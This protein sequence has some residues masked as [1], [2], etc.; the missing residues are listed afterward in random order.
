MEGIPATAAMP[1]ELGGR[2]SGTSGPHFRV[3]RSA[4]RLLGKLGTT[5]SGAL[6]QQP[7]SILD[8]GL[9]IVACLP[10]KQ[11]FK[12]SPVPGRGS[13]NTGNLQLPWGSWNLD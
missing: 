1:R 6:I 5:K 8:K 7:Y 4:P 11:G 13:R 12:Y 9:F 10:C 2:A 3:G